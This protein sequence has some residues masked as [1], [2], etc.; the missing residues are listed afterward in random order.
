MSMAAN[1]SPKHSYYRPFNRAVPT[2]AFLSRSRWTLSST[3]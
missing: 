3:V 2:C 1:S